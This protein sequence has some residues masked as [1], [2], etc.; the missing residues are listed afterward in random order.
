MNT[1]GPPH[2]AAARMTTRIAAAAGPGPG[3]PG[4]ATPAEGAPDPVAAYLDDDLEQLRLALAELAA[5]C[6]LAIDELNRR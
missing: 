3:D 1:P 2:T 6:M 4:P 5:R